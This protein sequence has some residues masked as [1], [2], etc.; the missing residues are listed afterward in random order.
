MHKGKRKAFTL[1]ELL[2]VVLIIAILAAIAIP[3]FMEFQTRAKVSR[4]KSD[5]RSMAT[6]M[7]AYCVDEG[8]YPAG[9]PRYVGP[10][11]IY[12]GLYRLT[13]PIAYM[14]NVPQDSFANREYQGAKVGKHFE[15]GVGKAGVHAANPTFSSPDGYPNDTW[16]LESPGPDNDEDSYGS[17]FASMLYPWVGRANN[18]A[19]WTLML[20]MLYDPTNG[21]VSSGTLYRAGGASPPEVVN[22]RWF[23][24]VTSK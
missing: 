1:I 9:T 4:V 13:T 20:S 10:E 2:I 21:T 6:G 17:Y 5:F 12:L 22:N 19:E 7:E 15:Y 16:M 23:Q 18:A 14:T 3:N 11:L 8:T 24:L